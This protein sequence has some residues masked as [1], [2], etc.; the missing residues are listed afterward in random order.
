M[1]YY[2]IGKAFPLAKMKHLEIEYKTLLTKAEYLQ[3][4]K[5]F[6]DVIPHEQ[7]NYYID[8]PNFEIKGNRM[9]LRIRTLSDKA[10]LTLKVPQEVGN[11][12]YNQDLD[13]E[14][15][16][17]LLANFKLP[18]GPIFDVL[19]SHYSIPLEKLQIWGSL[20]TERREKETSLG[21]MALDV[22]RY[23]NKQDYELEIEVADAESGKVGF[24]FFLK[25]HKITF[26]YASSKVARLANLL[27][28][29]R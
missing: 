1:Y 21:L 10:E 22:N 28:S 25:K 27:Q 19:H 13:L 9:S 14:T 20:T 17:N 29:A 8:T 26:K 3:L 4:Q 16:Q 6:S 12:E 7:T 5:E 18:A 23:A 11:M 2:T 15:A 24:D